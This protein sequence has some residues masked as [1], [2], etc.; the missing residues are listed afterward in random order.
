MPKISVIMPVY[1]TKEEFLREAIE[2]ILSQTF[3]DFELIIVD[4][5]SDK[6]IEDIVSSYS[7][8]RIVYHKMLKNSGA[9]E[10]RNYAIKNA[11]G[12]Y[13][14]FMD[15][16]DISSPERLEKQYSFLEKNKEIG[17]LGTQVRI[18]GKT[19][20]NLKPEKHEEI[21][22]KLLTSGCVF[23]QSSV[24]L[25]KNILENNNIFYKTKY[26]PAE[27][28]ALWLDLIG[29]TQFAILPDTLVYYRDHI[30]NISH[31]KAKIQRE[32]CILAQ[33]DTLERFFC[34]KIEKKKL[35]FHFLTKET[36]TEEDL[37]EFEQVL[38]NIKCK[39]LVNGNFEQLLTLLLR[40]WFKKGYR[41]TKG[42]RNQYHLLI[43]PIGKSF[44][45]PLHWR[46]FYFLKK[47]I[48]S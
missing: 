25:R 16:D 32:N 9:A 35:I 31:R 23:C 46:L 29:Y 36:Y 15:S 1:N 26:V 8:K 30:D 4:D 10:A 33:L 45:L 27:D 34:K 2:S 19:E 18:I 17:C 11:K 48:F 44:N 7:D 39:T 14:A 21:K 40:N 22:E 20:Q 24:M 6:F 37:E 47:G 28:Y 42:I 5:A 12:K 38:S 41:K 3:K 13:I 43:S